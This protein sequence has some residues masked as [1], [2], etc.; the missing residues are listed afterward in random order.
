MNENLS[1]LSILFQIM[2]LEMK[3]LRLGPKK[4]EGI[5]EVYCS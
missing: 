1:V 3:I 4:K 2:I 5:D